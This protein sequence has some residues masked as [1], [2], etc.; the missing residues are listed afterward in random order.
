MAQSEQSIA[1]SK[2]FFQALRELISGGVLKGKQT[3]TRKYGINRWNL[4]KIEAHPE[5]TALPI[6]WL[7]YLIV[8]FDVSAEWLMT[9]RGGMFS[10]LRAFKKE[11]PE[12]KVE[13]NKK[14][15]APKKKADK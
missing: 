8:D 1:I 9:G 6:A 15:A 5:T 7:S 11:D 4:N 2:R 14:K 10:G 13:A 3:F 12:S